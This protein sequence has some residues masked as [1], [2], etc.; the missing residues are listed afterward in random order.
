ML[1]L[2][3]CHLHQSIQQLRLIYY[4]FFLTHL[5]SANHS[6]PVITTLHSQL[7]INYTY[8][9]MFSLPN[10]ETSVVFH[11]QGRRRIHFLSD[12]GIYYDY[13]LSLFT[14]LISYNPQKINNKEVTAGNGVKQQS[15]CLACVRPKF[16]S[17]YCLTCQSIKCVKIFIIQ[18]FPA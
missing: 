2:I 18:P 7:F 1:Y 9:I 12:L 5:T 15:A 6:T 11:C 13:Y 17:Q 14:S 16:N 8:L 10:P 3:I 4:K